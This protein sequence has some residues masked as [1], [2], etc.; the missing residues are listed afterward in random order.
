MKWRYDCE[1]LSVFFFF[2]VKKKFSPVKFFGFPPV[3]KKSFPW[4]IIGNCP[5]KINSPREIF[6][7]NPPV[8]TKNVG[9]KKIKKSARE[10]HESARMKKSHKFSLKSCRKHTYHQ[11]CDD[12]LSKIP[13][14]RIKTHR[15]F[16]VSIIHHKFTFKSCRKHTYHQ[17]CDD[18][19]SKHPDF[20]IENIPLF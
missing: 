7:Q 1:L 3:K 18:H 19:L 14:F 9:V 4:K 20:R 10:N 11:F 5:W 17:F 8:K 13:D 12:F 15:C 2:P 6:C 16:K